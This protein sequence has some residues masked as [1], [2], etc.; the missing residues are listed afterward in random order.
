MSIK[1]YQSLAESL[2]E[3]INHHNYQ[4]YVL[5]APDIPDAEYDRLLRELQGIEQA[6]PEIISPDSPTQRVGAKPLERFSEIKHEV[7]MLSL[8]NAFNEKELQDFDRRILEKLEV[9]NVEYVGEPKLDGLAITIMYRDGMLDYAA[10]RGDGSTGEDVTQN[11][12]T[13]KT[14]PLKLSG[15]G[16]PK[17]LEVRGEVFISHK[18]FKLL[19]E[20]QIKKGEKVFANPRNAAA[21]SLRQLDSRITATRPLEIFFYGLGKVDG[22]NLSLS[23][24][25]TLKKLQTW[26]LRISPEAM[27]LENVEAC[28]D[29]YKKILKARESLPYEI[30]GVVFKINAYDFQK[31]MGQVARAPRWAIAH[32]FPAVEE[33]TRLLS[34]DVQVGRTGKVTPVARLEPVTVAGVTVSNATLHNQGEIDRKDVRIGDMVIVR[35]AGDVI[36]E[37]VSA[38]KSKRKKGARKFRMPTSCPVCGSDIVKPEDEAHAR[39]SG[40]LYCSAQRVEAIKHF[41]SRR[42]MDIEGLGDKLVEHLDETGLIKDVSDLFG[43]TLKQ[44]S[45]LDRMGEKSANNILLALEK[46]K[47]TTLDRFLFALGIRQVGEATASAL[48]VHFGNLDEIM[49]ADLDSLITVPDVGPVVAENIKQFFRDK[50]NQSV[51]RKLIKAGIHWPA[52]PVKIKNQ[53]LKGKTFVLTGTLASMSRENAKS[54]LKACGAKVSSSVSKKTDYVVAGEN[55][56]TK[57]SRAEALGVKIINEK[58]LEK[59]LAD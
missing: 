28:L 40:G 19:N 3:Q 53:K 36:P 39:C 49:R 51:I 10:T 34:I 25:E 38:I 20:S 56:G 1:N 48:A 54:R 17:V 52:K 31:K 33:M 7:P 6:H 13:I 58:A 24:F 11:I 14:V 32:K 50:H 37:V 23:H 47:T 8:G 41:A 4:Y 55:P 16:W 2:R 59:M 42:A 57:V 46:T 22:N 43:L 12:R 26:G 27:L 18:G 35:R 29:Y 45:E 15:N 9:D 5:D 30:D 21:G 44:L